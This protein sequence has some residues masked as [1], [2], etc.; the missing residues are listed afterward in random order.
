M[1]TNSILALI[2]LL[3]IILGLGFFLLKDSLLQRGS[4]PFSNP[5]EGS[6]VEDS[7]NDGVALTY[8]YEGKII[9]IIPIQNGEFEVKLDTPNVPQFFLT[10]DS[11]ILI[12]KDGIAQPATINDLKTGADVVITMTLHRRIWTLKTITIQ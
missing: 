8:N 5:L 10:K 11:Q 7:I 9:G 12:L 1:R 4:S 3:V 6:T 2:I